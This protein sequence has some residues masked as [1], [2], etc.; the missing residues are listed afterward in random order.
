VSRP[1]EPVPTPFVVTD[2][3]AGRPVAPVWVNDLGDLGVADRWADWRGASYGVA[4]DQDRMDDNLHM[5][6]DGD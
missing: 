2:I 3:A 4:P 5:W 1:T 6:K